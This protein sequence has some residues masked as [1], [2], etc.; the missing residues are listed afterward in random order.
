VTFQQPVDFIGCDFE[1]TVDFSYASFRRVVRFE[2]CVFKQ[3]AVFRG[4]RA[5]L[6]F[7]LSGS[8]FAAAKQAE[9]TVFDDVYVGGVLNA[10]GVRF[11]HVDFRRLQVMGDANFESLDQQPATFDGEASFTA[12][13]L[14]GWGGFRDATFGAA[15]STLEKSEDKWRRQIQFDRVVVGRD[16]DFSNARFHLPVTLHRARVGDLRCRGTQFLAIA[17]FNGAQI[18]GQATFE[19]S[20]NQP[21]VFCADADFY[22]AHFVELAQFEGVQFQGV[23]TFNNV[24]TGAAMSFGPWSGKQLV[25][26]A[27][28]EREARFVEARFGGP[29]RFNGATFKGDAQF[30]NS[31][32]VGTAQFRGATFEKQAAFDGARFDARA[33]FE[34]SEKDD[35]PAA[36]FEGETRFPSAVFASRAGFQHVRFGPTLFEAAR[37]N[38]VA[39][40]A[41]ALFSAK[42]D[43]RAANVEVEA[44]S[45]TQSSRASCVSARQR[46]ELYDFA[47]IG[48]SAIC[49]QVQRH[50]SKARSIFGAARTIGFTLRGASYSTSCSHGSGNPFSDWRQ[51]YAALTRMARPTMCT[52][53]GG[54]W[55]GRHFEPAIGG[56]GCVMLRT[57]F[58]RI[59]AFARGGSFG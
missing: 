19:P 40:F 22:G 14:G 54:V 30:Q 13:Q 45:T 34:P 3:R 50:S 4:A 55:S 57:G 59:M 6:D 27:L 5:E 26:G 28:F 25:Q 29:A 49:H 35:L 42:C 31:R 15:A 53:C 39:D 8:R 2:R 47:V 58:W 32:F 41:S 7:I 18:G 23:A 12:A 43:F 48:R 38:E 17:E 16:V 56:P 33:L 52:S 11:D 20:E 46:R 51:R 21:T 37:F 1:G 36:V 9:R 44:T 24:Q 10:R